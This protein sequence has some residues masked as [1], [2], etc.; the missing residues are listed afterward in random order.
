MRRVPFLDLV[1]GHVSSKPVRRFP[2]SQKFGEFTV[3]PWAIT[4][5]GV[6][7]RGNS[8]EMARS[9]RESGT[10]APPA[11]ETSP[12][13]L[14]STVRRLPTSLPLHTVSPPLYL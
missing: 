10:A 2:R 1:V 7:G 12:Q 8:D 5:A 9:R 14:T 4:V 11:K 6:A 13:G 3:T